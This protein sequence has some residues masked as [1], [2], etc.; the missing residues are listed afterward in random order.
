MNEQ[1]ES[2][3]FNYNIPDEAKELII[4]AAIVAANAELPAGTRFEIRGMTRTYSDMQKYGI[5]WYTNKMIQESQ[6]EDF[7]TKFCDS[8]E[9]D[10]IG[11][12]L[13]ASLITHKSAVS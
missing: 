13:I 4:D 5:A 7:R 8:I 1:G 10:E 2:I 9:L 12:V 11:C 6:A 3:R